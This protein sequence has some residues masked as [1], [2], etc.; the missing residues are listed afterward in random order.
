MLLKL[1]AV[2]KIATNPV[3]QLHLAVTTLLLS[4]LEMHKPHTHAYIL[5]LLSR[6]AWVKRHKRRN[7]YIVPQVTTVATV[8]LYVT[9]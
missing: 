9:G 7:T 6:V 2:F 3:V 1:D 4:Y 8:A 5:W